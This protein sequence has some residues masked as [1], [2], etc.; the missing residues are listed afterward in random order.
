MDRL[1]AMM[2]KI[3]QSAEE[4]NNAA[5]ML[6]QGSEQSAQAATQIAESI[7]RVAQSAAEQNDM[8]AATTATVEEI[9][10]QLDQV[11]EGTTTVLAHADEAQKKADNGSE[12][13]NKA[14]M[15]MRNIGTSVEESAKVVASLGERSQQIGQI[16]ETI[17]VIAEQ[18]NLLA[19]NAAIEA[20]RAGEAGRGFS[21]VADEVRKL[22]ESS[23]ESVTEIAA[24]I[25]GIQADTEAAVASMQ[26]GNEET[27]SG[28]AIMDQAGQTFGE[29]VTLMAKM[30]EE[31][32]TMS[33]SINTVAIGADGIVDTADRLSEA[34]NSVSSETQTVSAAT[35]EQSAS[36]EEIASS[37]H[38]LSTVSQ[39]LQA[40]LQ[41]FRI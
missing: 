26:T 5:E 35:E 19:L 13:I 39:A 11:N 32:K 38:N 31:I 33:D 16:V 36:V 20:A 14:V 30:N 41:K 4:S 23:S 2:R 27:K 22:A 24:L 8:A 29:I 6:R 37:A 28:V 21:V 25:H 9:R 1:S 7:T 15:Q 10:K 3:Q 34:S 18:T 17:S 40:E 12:A